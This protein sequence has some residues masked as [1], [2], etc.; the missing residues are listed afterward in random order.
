[1][2]LLYKREYIREGGREGGREVWKLLIDFL[3]SDEA[4]ILLHIVYAWGETEEL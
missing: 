1:M 4:L 3:I 2:S